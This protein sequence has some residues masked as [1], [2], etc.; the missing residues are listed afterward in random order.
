[1]QFLET[2]A[3]TRRITALLTDDEYRQLQIR[4]IL[5]PASGVLIRGGGGI[6]KIRAASSSHGRRGGSRVIYFWAASSSRILM[7][8][9]YA[10]NE[11][12]DL[13]PHQV[14]QLAQIVRKELASEAGTL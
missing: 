2:A 4:L 10:K 8:F 5:N 11:S 14:R 1:M 12:S 9:A 6:R 3:F 7:L 13:T